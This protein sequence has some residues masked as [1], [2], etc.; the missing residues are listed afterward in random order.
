MARPR[1]WSTVALLI[2]MVLWGCRD[3]PDLPAAPS[4]PGST[5]GLPPAKPLGTFLDARV[6]VC[7]TA[8]TLA[9]V[10]DVRVELTGVAATR[11]LVCRASDGSADMTYH[12]RKTRQALIVM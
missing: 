8:D 6:A 10:S 12:M 1:T 5:A 3:G 2:A 11:P 9:T 4:P 7:P